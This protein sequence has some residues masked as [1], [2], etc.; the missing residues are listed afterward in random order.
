MFFL[1]FGKLGLKALHSSGSMELLYSQGVHQPPDNNGQ[2]NNSKPEATK[3]D[4]GQAND[5]IYHRLEN[6]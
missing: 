4:V 6:D 2:D 5:H 1:E 3:Q